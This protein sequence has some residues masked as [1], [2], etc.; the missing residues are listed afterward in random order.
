MRKYRR[1]AHVLLFLSPLVLFVNS[2]SAAAFKRVHEGDAAPSFALADLAGSPVDLQSFKDGPLTIVTF[3]AL[4]SPKSE[5]LL[6]DVQRLLDEFGSKGVRAVGLKAVAVNAEGQNPPADLDA[7]VKAYLDKNGISFPV[8]ID[9]KLELYDT[10]GVIALPA[11]AFLGKD[12]KV[13]YEFSGH[14]TS[15]Y[16]DMRDKVLETLGIKE[17]LAE[18]QKPKRER[19][20][21]AAKMT[22]LNYGMAR[23]LY[24]RGQFSQ[25]AKKLDKVLAD[26]PKFP[27]AQALQGA[28][29]LGFEREG[30]PDA[31]Q[32]AREAFQKAV[33][34]DP[35]VPMGLAGLAH[36]ALKDG[37]VPKALELTKKALEF[38]ESPEPRATTSHRVR[39]KPKAGIVDEAAPTETRAIRADVKLSEAPAAEA[40]TE[41]KAPDAAVEET[42]P[43]EAANPAAAVAAAETAVGAGDTAS[44][45]AELEKAIN[46]VLGTPEGPRMKREGLMEKLQKP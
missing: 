24:E 41:E 34:L 22:T 16:E 35:T 33:E 12:L 14:P 45:T 10:W 23:T 8:V 17:Q 11:T 2:T 36:F 20:K 42:P 15:A 18:A 32:A 29:Q 3:W 13:V 44:A 7:Q 38:E 43:R 27:D 6:Q 19:Y 5:P 1:L 40:V 9:R 46:T 4:W 31:A 30:R 37:D 21:P 28:I 39:G 26:E 25:A